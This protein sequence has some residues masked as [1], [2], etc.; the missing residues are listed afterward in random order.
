MNGPSY[1]STG[2]ALRYHDEGD[3]LLRT[4]GVIDR[5]GPG[6]A[7]WTATVAFSDDRHPLDRSRVVGA[8][9][10]HHPMPAGEAIDLV[11]A[12]AESL[13][14]TWDNPPELSVYGL[15]YISW[16]PPLPEGWRELVKAQCH[17]L[18]WQAGPRLEEEIAEGN[19]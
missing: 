8:L 10:T 3:V 12:D 17:R 11:K 15:D 6:G 14:I 19:R 2:I 1:F 4:T 5:V 16:P 18:G 13:G 7:G 9:S